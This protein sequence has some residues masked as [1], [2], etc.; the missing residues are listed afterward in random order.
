LTKY[1]NI[2]LLVNNNNHKKYNY[3]EQILLDMQKI[4]P[5][6]RVPVGDES[7][8]KSMNVVQAQTTQKQ[9]LPVKFDA[10]PPPPI[11]A[12]T[13]NQIRAAY[14]I[15]SSATGAGAKIAIVDIMPPAGYSSTKII[16][17][18][19]AFCS[20]YGLPNTGLSIFTY[21]TSKATAPTN[22]QGWGLEICLDIQWAHV[23]APQASIMLILVANPAAQTN[24]GLAAA[25]S[26]AVSLGANI[27]SMSFGMDE[28]N[29]ELSMGFEPV[30]QNPN[31]TFIAS[32]G[33]S[34]G[35]L[36]YPAASSNVISVGGTSLGI[37]SN[38]QYVA[39]CAWI[40]SGGGISRYVAYPQYQINANLFTTRPRG[41]CIP[42]VGFVGDP[43]TGVPVYCT[44]TTNI[45]PWYQ[46]GG[47]SLGAPAWAGICALLYQKFG[48]ASVGT[49]KLQNFLYTMYKNPSQYSNCFNDVLIGQSVGSSNSDVIVA[50]SCKTGYDLITGIG[51]PN[52]GQ[53]LL[54]TTLPHS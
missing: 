43:Y 6:G 12:L 20:R 54:L 47:T 30:F 14:N 21:P 53:M 9:K 44:E 24:S 28:F 10:V 34:G 23:I 52:V 25:I 19:N 5:H 39:E 1:Y 17:D 15:P 48:T 8:R 7:N 36:C 3:I 45:Q 40:A 2:Q 38:G 22:S 51:T 13:P 31:V 18:Y 46:V 49:A 11:S 42:D 32:A 29:G 27:V 50:N 37:K 33:D 35:E 26:Y 4:K 41:R 16:S